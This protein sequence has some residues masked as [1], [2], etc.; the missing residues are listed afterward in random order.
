MTKNEFMEKLAKELKAR[1]VADA[2]DIEEEYEQ[3][4]ALSWRTAT[5]RR[6][7]P[8]NSATRQSSPRSSVRRAPRRVRAERRPPL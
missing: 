6:R 7:L 3:H 2:A 1:G 8:R 4:F 5:P